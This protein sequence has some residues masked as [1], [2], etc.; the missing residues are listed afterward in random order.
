[1]MCKEILYPIWPFVLTQKDSSTSSLLPVTTT[2]VPIKFEES[3]YLEIKDQQ[4]WDGIWQRNIKFFLK[5]KRAIKEETNP[6]SKWE[7][8]LTTCKEK[9][10]ETALE[11]KIN[12]SA[13]P[14]W[15]CVHFWTWRIH[16]FTCSF[17]LYRLIDREEW[18]MLADHV[19]LT[20]SIKTL[21]LVVDSKE[22]SQRDFR[23]KNST[24]TL[25]IGGTEHF[26]FMVIK[27]D[28][29]FK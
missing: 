4:E 26:M 13:L 23:I 21:N 20:C 25:N 2:E 16:G 28:S 10:R 19:C 11:K 9:L 24:P 7:A 8:C 15:K 14:F 29:L 12:K 5:K 18:D 6:Q 22:M 17:Y 1:M 27:W 3:Y